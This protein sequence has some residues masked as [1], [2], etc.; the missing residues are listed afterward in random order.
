MKTEIKTIAETD[1][2][3]FGYWNTDKDEFI[4]LSNLTADEGLEIAE[5]FGCNP[6]LIDALNMFAADIADAVGED[7][8]DIWKRINK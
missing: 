2:L 8:K 1:R 3:V 5:K 4:D 6:L 7:L